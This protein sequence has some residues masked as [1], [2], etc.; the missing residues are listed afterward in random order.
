M[1][2]RAGVGGC[3]FHK[4]HNLGLDICVQGV[5]LLF[6]TFSG[7]SSLKFGPELSHNRAITNHIQQ[8]YLV[9]ISKQIHTVRNNSVLDTISTY[10]FENAETQLQQLVVQIIFTQRCLLL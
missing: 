9:L 8:E 4:C 1:P 3:F 7:Q 2:E 5:F 10:L 6:K